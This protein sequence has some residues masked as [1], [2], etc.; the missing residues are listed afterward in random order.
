MALYRPPLLLK[1]K[2]DINVQPEIKDALRGVEHS[3]FYTGSRIG[4]GDNIELD[5]CTVLIDSEENIYLRT[6]FYSGEKDTWK[7]VI[8]DQLIQHLKDIGLEN[9]LVRSITRYFEVSKEYHFKKEKYENRLL[10][11]IANV[12]RER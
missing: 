5:V 8:K 11:L 2:K 7:E 1:S 4:K 9:G 10:D 3:Y 6:C 12:N